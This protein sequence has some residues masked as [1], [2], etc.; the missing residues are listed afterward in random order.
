MPGQPGLHDAYTSLPPFPGLVR[1]AR[2]ESCRDDMKSGDS[3]QYAVSPLSPSLPLLMTRM[4]DNLYIWGN[5]CKSAASIIPPTVAAPPAQSCG[6]I[7]HPAN[8]FGEAL[9]PNQNPDSGT[10]EPEFSSPAASFPTGV[11]SGPPGR[12]TMISLGDNHAAAITVRG[13]LLTWGYNTH[14]QCG[15]HHADSQGAQRP[16]G[17]HSDFSS[18]R[19]LPPQLVRFPETAA[20]QTRWQ[21]LQVRTVACGGQHTLAITN[22]GVF[23][24][25]CNAFGQCGLGINT[26][27]KVLQPMGVPDLR[28]VSI[29]QL[30]AGWAHSLALTVSAQVLSWGDGASGQLGHGDR[31][32]RHAP[33]AIE[34]L[35]GL[36][37]VQ[38]AAGNKHS[39][40]VTASGH[41]FLWGCNSFGQLG[42]LPEPGQEAQDATMAKALASETCSGA[43]ARR[44]DAELEQDVEAFAREMAGRRSVPT[45]APELLGIVDLGQRRDRED[46]GQQRRNSYFA[47]ETAQHQTGHPYPQNCRPHVRREVGV[48][49]PS[50]SP[51]THACPLQPDSS[52]HSVVHT[53]G[54]VRRAALRRSGA[55]G[56]VHAQWLLAM[57][58]MGIPQRHARIA[59]EETGNAGVEVATEWLFTAD[60]STILDELS[61]SEPASSSLPSTSDSSQPTRT[62]R[63][64]ATSTT[65]TVCPAE[66]TAAANSHACGDRTNASIISNDYCDGGTGDSAASDVD[67]GAGSSHFSAGGSGRQGSQGRGCRDDLMMV[68]EPRRVPLKDVRYLAAGGRHTV[69]VTDGGVFAWGDGASGALGLGDCEGREL[70]CRLN[71]FMPMASISP[72]STRHPAASAIATTASTYYMLGNGG[73][74]DAAG[75][76]GNSVAVGSSAHSTVNMAVVIQRVACGEEHTL[77]L[78]QDGSVY[79][80]GT[81][82]C[83]APWPRDGGSNDG[84]N[85]TTSTEILNLTQ[86]W[87]SARSEA[88]VLCRARTSGPGGGVGGPCRP[89]SSGRAAFSAVPRQLKMGLEQGTR[90]GG[91][92]WQPVAKG[93]IAGPVVYQIFARGTTSAV[94]MC[95][96]HELPQVPNPPCDDPK[97]LNAL[98]AAIRSVGLVRRRGGQGDLS[99]LSASLK[100]VAVGVRTVFSSPASINVAFG[101]RSGMGLDGQLLEDV[102]GSIRKLFV[103]RSHNVINGRSGEGESIMLRV[104]E[105][106]RCNVLAAVRDAITALVDDLAAHMG[107][108]GTPERAQVLLAALQHPLLSDPNCARQ[109]L[110]KLVATVMGAAPVVRTW[111]VHWWAEY[112]GPLL[113][114]RVVA[115]LQAY[116]TRELGATKRLTTPLMDVIKVLARVAEAA[117]RSNSLPPEAFYNA[118]VSEK[119]DVQ[120]HY[121]A[122]R[123]AQELST[124]P[125]PPKEAPFSFCSYP[126]LLNAR[127]KSQ[128][129]HLEARFQMEQS[130]AHARMEVQLYG[131]CAA[132][133]RRAAEGQ[134]LVKSAAAGAC[135][136]NSNG[137]GHCN[138][139]NGQDASSC[140]ASARISDITNRSRRN[141]SRG[142]G[143]TSTRRGSGSSCI[144]SGSGIVSDSL[145]SFFLLLR[146]RISRSSRNGSSD[147]GGST[148]DDTECRDQDGKGRYLELPCPSEC[149][150][151]GVHSDMCIVRVRRTHLVE[152]ALGELGRQARGD[153]LKPL[154]VHFI[155]EEGIDAG[156]VKKEFFSLLVER[157]LSLDYGMMSY[158]E[159]SR[160]YW[161]N[162]ASLEPSDSYFLLGVVLGLAVYNRVLLA[163]PAPLLLYQKLRGDRELGLRDLEAWQPELAR[164][165]RLLLE[166]DGPEP[167]SEVFGLTFSVVVDRFGHFETVPLKPDGDQI[168]VTEYNR[169]EYVSLLA[170]W[171]MGGNVASQ[172]EAFTAG[173]R[174][175]CR[176][177]AMSLFNAQE[178][179]RLVCGNPRLDFVALRDAARYEGGYTRDSPA[180]S[181][182]WDIV[183][184]ELRA[185]D[186]RAFLKF[187]TGSDRS[188]LG[189]LGSLRPVIQRDGPDSHKLPTAHTCFNTLLL[190]EYCNREK[191]AGLLQLAINNSEGFGLQ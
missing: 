72:Q 168:P 58:E 55:A 162:P 32:P 95:S 154:R 125:D 141:S 74:G 42:L 134:V 93:A 123:Q 94:L 108:L 103:S 29:C 148:P 86:S 63:G 181:W 78:A 182:L 75:G 30:A 156:G 106:H 81:M 140:S 10:I 59:L 27:D 57:I 52:Q 136:G 49:Y 84:T 71:A 122:W 17:H 102:L 60:R 110:P 70:P 76:G 145:R 114:S 91:W 82:P 159:A 39:A 105:L 100:E 165:M 6:G 111:L 174:V 109:L 186:Q 178:L 189:G 92:A 34:A 53:P 150:M 149:P 147:R 36:P 155:G 119:L 144:G 142:S 51:G 21:L 152:D 120:D 129:L 5:T 90:E 1:T 143:G 12:F 96:A 167:M 85:A 118:L 66:A 138:S 179:E 116:L 185:E 161:F 15:H 146:R 171:H 50:G 62:A 20:G 112:P 7:G 69:A 14:G 24:W 184:H 126:F 187:F 137:T 35:W 4:Q 18:I 158:D 176:G 173:F 183:L 115:P 8:T 48:R 41:A 80:C 22:A 180:V 16:M 77:F 45:A 133:E 40:A 99:R 117:S 157:L 135:S 127:A 65:A 107:L 163:F 54:S 73:N 177:P 98:R 9:D 128:L 121:S 26:P 13:E 43:D 132:A 113:E 139:S 151:P 87:Q 25:G 23:A 64:A 19:C 97:S 172:F 68:T 2:Q 188:P 38:I 124:G 61:D 190:P 169:A 37:V 153:L 47:T 101:R 28:R 44:Q 166:Y 164:G 170:A 191:L 83:E 130:V 79:W 89:C 104:V 33:S 31:Q 67:C 3:L 11:C 56:Q 88:D 131:R 46:A 175:V 160:T